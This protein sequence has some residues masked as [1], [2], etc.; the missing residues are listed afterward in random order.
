[1]RNKNVAAGG[2][3]IAVVVLAVA[4]WGLTGHGA[5]T[6]AAGS[7][8]ATIA[9]TSVVAPATK[10]PDSGG[11]RDSKKAAI[12]G[13]AATAKRIEKVPGGKGVADRLASP[14]TAALLARILGVSTQKA[15]VALAQLESSSADGQLDPQSTSFRSVADKLGLS[16]AELTNGLRQLK[17]Q[18][19]GAQPSGSDTGRNLLTEPRSAD[20]VA[21]AL[22]VPAAKAATA[23]AKLAKQSAEGWLDPKSSQFAAVAGDLGVS[24]AQLASALDNLKKHS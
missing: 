13:D 9:S 8:G 11:S 4:G 19:V 18:M 5:A 7:A 24:P 1:V 14:E 17:Q 12:A 10:S 22:H 3:G 6:Q 2:T 15:A 16:A 21:A 23:L 20:I